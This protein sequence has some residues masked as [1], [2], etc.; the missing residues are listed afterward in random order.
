MAS[1]HR[2]AAAILKGFKL[3]SQRLSAE[4]VGRQAIVKRRVT[5]A[6]EQI[7]A[8]LRWASYLCALKYGMNLTLDRLQQ[9]IMLGFLFRAEF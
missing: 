4:F 7:P 2:K 5:E 1:G 6:Q 3:P 9:A 8:W